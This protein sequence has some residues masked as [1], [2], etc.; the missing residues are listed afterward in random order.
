MTFLSAPPPPARLSCRSKTGQTGSIL[1]TRTLRS[2]KGRDLFHVS[3]SWGYS[4]G[5]L[6]ARAF[7]CTI[8][9]LLKTQVAGPQT[10]SFRLG[11]SGMQLTCVSS[12]F[13]GDVTL[14]DHFET[15]AT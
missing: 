1:R 7:L 8:W 3:Q 13:P 9:G 6:A 15:L 14:L 4:T 12:T 5:V 10:Q 2:E 11:R